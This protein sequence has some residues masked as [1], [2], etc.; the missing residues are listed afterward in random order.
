[1]PDPLFGTQLVGSFGRHWEYSWSYTNSCTTR[2]TSS[3]R[4]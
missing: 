2:H 1:M 4:F 3:E